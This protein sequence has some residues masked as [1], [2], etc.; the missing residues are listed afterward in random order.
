MPA[1][2]APSR[3]LIPDRP[4]GP[5][6]ASYHEVGQPLRQWEWASKVSQRSKAR[7]CEGKE[8]IDLDAYS[9]PKR[10]IMLIAQDFAGTHITSQAD[11]CVSNQVKDTR[12]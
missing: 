12:C 10:F 5:A 8:I 7:K 1:V 3:R 6:Q 4:R 11:T 9:Y 2:P